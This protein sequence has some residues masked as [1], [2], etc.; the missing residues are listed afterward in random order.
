MNI[1]YATILG[2]KTRYLETEGGTD[3]P[4]L[5]L[6]GWGSSVNSWEKVTEKIS[7]GGQRVIMPDL[8]GFGETQEPGNPWNIDD[9]INFL[10]KFTEE[11][12]ISDFILAGHSFGGQIAISWASNQNPKIKALILMG[13]ARIAKHKKLKAQIFVFF[14]KIGN[15]P[16]EIPMIKSLRPLVRKIWYKLAGE[17]DYYK[18]SELMRKTMGLVLAQEV[19]DR[20]QKI[21]IPALILWGDKDMVTPLADGKIIN[22]SVQ[23]SKLLVLPGAGHAINAEMPNEVSKAILEFISKLNP[24]E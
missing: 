21:K 7:F 2:L 5:L 12:N 16:F 3:T 13:A 4:L 9:Y 18:S 15:L 1:K 19:G 6:H 14:T 22:Q 20:L 24:K 10:K 8:P 17:K 23:N 11:L